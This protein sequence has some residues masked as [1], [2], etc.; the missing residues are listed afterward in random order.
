VPVDPDN[1]VQFVSMA[2]R[3]A[4]RNT[5]EEAD[6]LASSRAEAISML[7]EALRFA[8]EEPGVTSVAIAYSFS[9]GSYATQIPRRGNQIGALAGAVAAMGWKL[10]MRNNT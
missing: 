5:Q 1:V 6:Y 2:Q 8:R 3:E 9:S 4:E 10:Q 7:E